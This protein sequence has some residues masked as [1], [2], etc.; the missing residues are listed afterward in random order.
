MILNTGQ[1]TD[2]PA[3]YSEWFINRIE[4]GEV[5]SRNPYNPQ[6]VIRYRLDPEVVDLLVFGTKNPAPLLPHLEKLSRFSQLWHITITPYGRDIE[7]N[8]P[9]VS[10]VVESVK[11]LSKSIGANRIFWRYD[12]VFISDKYSADFHKRAFDKIAAALSGSAQNGVIS[13]I[14]LYE[15]TV[16]NFPTVTE[17]SKPL[18]LELG[19]SF[20]GS[21]KRHGIKL[22][23][24]CE[25]EELSRFGIDTQGC[26]TKEVVQGVIG[27][28]LEMPKPQYA[29]AQCRCL[30]GNDIGAYNTCPHMCKY[31]Y[32]NY[33]SRIVMNNYRNHDPD[34]PLLLG[35]LNPED[36]VKDAKQESF[37]FGQMSF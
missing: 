4:A 35:R 1:R 7:P 25:D 26:M 19:E 34:S 23:A 22:Y 21:A 6:Q 24:C 33:D 8:V 13:F 3:Y 12:P 14:D 20:A 17:V 16:R 37:I 31:C 11:A 36:T 18:R 32:A 9:P 30:L 10:E 28:R 27:E 5:L 2:I 29:R 15:K